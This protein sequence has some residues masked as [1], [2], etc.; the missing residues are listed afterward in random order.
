MV[1]HYAGDTVCF[2]VNILNAASDPSCGPVNVAVDPVGGDPTDVLVIGTPDFSTATDFC[3]TMGPDAGTLQV[4]V[5][6]CNQTNSVLLYNYGVPKT[7]GT[8]LLPASIPPAT[9]SNLAVMVVTLTSI[10][11]DWQNNAD[12]ELGFQIQRATSSGGPWSVVGSVG[13]NVTSYL[14]AGLN[15]STTFYYQV[16][17]FN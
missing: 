14:D 15:S 1:L 11:L 16:A 5:S 12:N 2:Q 4:T 7:T 3:L 9:P 6:T 17:A 8:T 13:A 10:T